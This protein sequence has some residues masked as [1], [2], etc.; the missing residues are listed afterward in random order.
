MTQKNRCND[1]DVKYADKDPSYKITCNIPIISLPLVT[2]IQAQTYRQISVVLSKESRGR[3]S[4]ATVNKRQGKS[5]NCFNVQ[6]YVF[7][8]T[9]S[10]LYFWASRPCILFLKGQ[11]D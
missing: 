8:L 4:M 7:Y 3:K 1:L 6:Y 9:F 2:G 10:A 11:T 5:R